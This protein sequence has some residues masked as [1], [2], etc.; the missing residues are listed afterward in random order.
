MIFEK[1]DESSAIR[2]QMEPENDIQKA[3][4]KTTF[5]EVKKRPKCSPGAPN[6]EPFARDVCRFCKN[7]AFSWFWFFEETRVFRWS[8]K[9]NFRQPLGTPLAGLMCLKPRPCRVNR[10]VA[11]SR[12]AARARPFQMHFRAPKVHQKTT[13]DDSVKIGFATV[14]MNSMIL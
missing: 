12:P 5:Q 14:S 6:T 2:A 7:G 11:A 3:H 13:N 8:K 10:R 4:Q 1:L 9:N